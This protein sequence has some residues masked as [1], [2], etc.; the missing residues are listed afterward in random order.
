MITA[1]ARAAF[2]ALV[3]LFVCNSASAHAEDYVWRNVRV[4]GGG[5]IPQIVFSRV[6]P[7]LAYLR[8]DMGG[9][10]RW[11]SAA[12]RWIPLQDGMAESNYFGIESV[13]PDPVDSNLIYLAAGMYRRESA[14]ILRSRDRGATWDVRPV[15]F[16]MGGNED[17]RGLGERLAI[18]PNDTSILYFGSRH[19]GLQRSRDS[20]ATWERVTSFPHAGRGTPPQGQ[21]T[22]AGISFVIFDPASGTR[23]AGSRTIFVG[24]ADPGEQHLYRSNDAGATWAPVANQPRAD[25]LPA[26]AQLDGAGQLYIAYSVGIGPSGV[27][28]GAVYRL[29]TRTGAWTD[30]TPPRAGTTREGGYMGISVDR[31]AANT[32][33]VATMNRW[34][35]G[36]TIW[37]ST[38][39]GRTWRDLRAHSRHDVSDTPFLLW[40]EPEADFG[41]WMAG[42]AIDPFNSDF[43]SYTTGATIYATRDLR[44]EALTWRPWVE[45]VE[46]TAIITL[47]A[48]PQG[49]LLLSG[50]GDISGFAH[51]DLSASPQAQFVNPVFANTNTID[52]A[53][54]APNIVVRSG[55]PPHRATGGEPVFA[56]STDAGRTW[57]PIQA[58]QLND[59]TQAQA[60]ARGDYAIA[61]SADGATFVAMT[62]NP[63]R[64][65]DR[66]A[67]WVGIDAPTG[68]RPVADRVEARTFYALDFERGRILISRDGA[69]T[70]APQR[71]R[72]L[73]PAI[74][75]DRPTNRERPWPLHTTPGIAGDLWVVSQ[76]G[77]Y[78][79][80]DAGRVFN[81]VVSGV[82]IEA[83]SFGKAPEG[84]AYPAL[85]AIGVRDGVRAIW[86][87]DDQGA[88]WIRINDADHEYGRRFRCIA[89]DMRVFGRVYVGADGRG[90]LYGELTR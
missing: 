48:P 17:G 83:L 79:S 75:A 90:I 57:T 89:G 82:R 24:I 43:L 3:L 63:L 16:R 28:G 53:S 78:H 67:T 31:Q 11:D 38:D 85:F 68:T 12:A 47:N 32:L 19:D 30:I 46:Q 26:Q 71:T 20:G 15:S 27:T 49:P 45:G 33:V 72:G 56:Y 76:Q 62:P 25:L 84:A 40:G 18:D 61:T 42:L 37:R 64:T 35:G 13:A 50:F 51:D 59:A 58:P 22:N 81:R 66:G 52:Y 36:D 9:A 87:S 41:W 54:A 29:N 14:A 65:R 2:S 44:G 80:T 74:A 6:E 60:L 86:R 1:F 8:S 77:L 73:P 5:F 23:G 7:G 39:A 34:D 55:T 10:Y 88:N 69:D 70:F 4:G 21:P